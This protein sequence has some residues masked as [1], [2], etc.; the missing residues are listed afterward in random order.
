[1]VVHRV[2]LPGER[3]GALARNRRLQSVWQPINDPPRD[4]LQQLQHFNKQSTTDPVIPDGD[5]VRLPLEANLEIG[6][7]AN[8]SEEELEYVV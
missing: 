8:L 4:Q 6:I 2:V 7:L 5:I 3:G 1:M